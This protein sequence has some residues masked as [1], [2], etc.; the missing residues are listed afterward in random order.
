MFQLMVTHL[1]KLNERVAERISSFP[2]S[3][4]LT[5]VKNKKRH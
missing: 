4:D 2:V 5:T 1:F 3:D